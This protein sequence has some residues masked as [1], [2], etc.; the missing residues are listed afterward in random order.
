MSEVEVVSV[1]KVG[2]R[3]RMTE[4]EPVPGLTCLDYSVAG[5]RV[6]GSAL[7]VQ[8]S[9]SEVLFVQSCSCVAAFL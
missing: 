3:Q 4:P 6:T 7:S 1:L 9:R 8:Y 5:G 2:R